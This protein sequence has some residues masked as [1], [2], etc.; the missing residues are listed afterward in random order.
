MEP[1]AKPGHAL[2]DRR[3]KA[4]PRIL[5][6]L[7]KGAAVFFVVVFAALVLWLRHYGLPNIDHYRADIVASIEKA[8]GM[9]ATVKA[10]R[11]GWE[12]LRPHVT[13][14]G[15]ALADRKGRVGLAFERAEANLSWW[16]LLAGQV[17]FHDVD[18]YR[19][20][21]FLRRGADG[22]IYLA[23]KP[24]NAAGQGEG[25]FTEWLLGQ[26]R[27]GIHDATLTWRDEKAN[28]PEL[29]LSGVQIAVE[30]HLGRYHAAL[31]AVPP[32]EL[33][34][35][36][37]MRAD[38]KLTRADEKWRADGEIYV[39]TRHADLGK[40]RAHL[41][42]PETLRSGAG[43]M[44]VWVQ[45]GAQGLREVLADL[46]VRDA[47]AQLAEDALPL[48]LASL[49]GRA[50]YRAEQDGFSFGTEGLRFRLASGMEVRPG[51][52]S[53]KRVVEAGKPARVDVRA[54]D[55]DVKI[56]ATLLEYFPVPR[57][58]KGQV[59]R[60]A[61]RGRIRDA[62][63][64][65]SGAPGTPA[66]TYTVKGRFEDL[67]I[68]PVDNFPGVSGLTGRIEGT[69]AA[70]TVELDSKKVGFALE[71]IF[72]APLALD[73]LAAHIAWK[74]AGAALEVAIRDATFANADAEGTFAGTWRTMPEKERPAGFID[75]KGHLTRANAKS[76]AT[77]LPNRLAITRDWLERSIQSGA[78]TNVNFEL[79]GDLATFP[80]ADGSGRF[81]IEGDL[82]DGRLKYH[83]DWPSVD[84]VQGSFRFE[85]PRMEIRA[86]RATIFA[87]RATAVT[88]V[89]EN[90]VVKPPLL[91]ID[92]DVDTS[93]ADS[94]RFLRES[95][96]VN[97]PGAFTRAV[98]VEGPG[99]L[100]LHLE[101]PIGPGEKARVRG[102]YTFAGANASVGKN[103]A[104]RD[105][106]GRLSF[107]ERGVS[108]PE[109][110][111]AMFGKPAVL[112][113]STQPD[114]QILTSIDGHIDAPVF[115]TYVPEAI[116]S[117]LT[118]GTD[119]NARLV[120]GRGGS[121]LTVTSDLQSMGS[122]LPAPLGKPEGKPRPFMITMARLGQESEVTTLAL[123]GGI[124][125]RFHRAGAPGAERWNA[126]LK[127]GSP[128]ASEP[129][130]EGVWLYGELDRV[131][132]D[133]WQSVFARAPDAPPAEPGLME[134]RG[135]DLKLG[136]ALF[137]KREFHD[138]RAQLTRA[139][140]QWKGRLDSPVIAGDVDWDSQ[141]KGRL[142]AKLERFAI[143]ESTAKSAAEAPAQ[144]GDLP[145][146][147]IAAERFDFR[148]KRLGKLDLKAAPVDDEWR[149]DKLDIVNDHAQFRST[150][151]FRRTGAGAITTLAVKLETDSVNALLGQFG[152]ADYIKGGSGKLEGELVW[153]GYPYE[154]ALANL[155]GQY[156]VEANRGQF[157]KMQQGAGKLLALISLQSLP[158]HAT[159]D[160][161]DVFSEGFA[162]ERIRGDVKVARG[163]LL[164]D[165]F[166]IAGPS[167]FVSLAGEVS[168][169]QETQTLTMHIV[170][171]VGEAAA[172][173]ATLIGTPVLGLSTL[174]VSK[175]LRN[176]LGKIV[177][178]EYQ[179]TGSWDNPEVTRLSAP[180]AKPAATTAAAEAPKDGAKSANP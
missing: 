48:E 128:V 161:S 93:G 167:A 30:K 37:D 117:H 43:G 75:V 3:I 78:A 52:F 105:M 157:A 94:V 142:V 21:L 4:L 176:P 151:R 5:L 17:R 41:P 109:I 162:F 111:G 77:Y 141:G 107:T 112:T 84:A 135:L 130:R 45:F 49:S 66:A 42:V 116:A 103:L 95:P 153:P 23:D 26:P 136:E 119:W 113:M 10:I 65:W 44:R 154:F 118:G 57:D 87:S 96:L 81:L 74:R 177:A 175:L 28:A 156:K 60:F 50:R 33:A 120:S 90:L 148:G 144:K 73:T 54:N 39:E 125:G 72:R 155:A 69:Q 124:Y 143:P 82:R 51:D 34:G 126:A 32:R 172:V 159:F 12:G 35:R 137:S 91:V 101:F 61:P 131:D 134:L 62:F 58:V 47:R 16:A 104:F 19:P 114:G 36:I 173:A 140:T 170:P 20:A 76:V 14:E 56:A 132:V 108:A 22:L 25:R 152:Y 89:I 46:D 147:D 63:V 80:F 166:E 122:T 27:L 70:G 29:E 97:G 64:T 53:V 40:L 1:G 99:R 68:N 15:F 24:L 83:A 67:A 150:G 38:V 18:F 179:I 171:E 169:P 79:R 8:S 86:E 121:E 133:A 85:G 92:G 59:L 174:V 115:A 106:Q 178:F 55:I 158:R 123:E 102:D 139:G 127:F 163:V 100:K 11:G 98:A 149:I 138:V 88:A 2:G 160:F 165:N 145:A 6:R 129:S 71:R 180:P 13:L 9:A 164:T 110:K 31:I 7:A 146:L 168:L